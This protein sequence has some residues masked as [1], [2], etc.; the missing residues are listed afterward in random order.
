MLIVLIQPLVRHRQTVT[1]LRPI[2]R[3]HALN[4]WSSGMF[5]LSITFMLFAF[6]PS[7]QAC[8]H[9]SQAR[10]RCKQESPS[11]KQE[12]TSAHFHRP[13][14][15]CPSKAGKS[16]KVAGRA[17]GKLRPLFKRWQRVYDRHRFEAHADNAFEQ[18][19]D[20]AG[21]VV[22]APNRLGHCG[23]RCLCPRDAIA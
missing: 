22:P 4:A 8:Q 11:G 13:I 20:V 10:R 12:S 1:W 21:L 3:H 7:Q 16:G 5:S 17:A 6:H 9:P 19:E 23:C 18:V 2:W 15:A 14:H